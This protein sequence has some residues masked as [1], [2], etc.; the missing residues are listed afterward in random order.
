MS[1][2]GIALVAAALALN[3]PFGAY[4]ATVRRLSPKWFLAIHLPI[5]FIFIL[6][7]SAGYGYSFIPWLVV[8][9]VAGQLAGARL[10]REYRRRRASATL[11]PAAPDQSVPGSVRP[12]PVSRHSQASA[13]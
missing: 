7:V 12:V 13:D 8:G 1:P 2:I 5:P 3:L 11:P 9:A 4:R 10:W 6:R